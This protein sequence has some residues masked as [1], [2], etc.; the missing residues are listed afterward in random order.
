MIRFVSPITQKPLVAKDYKTLTC[1]ESGE[2]FYKIDGIWRMLD[3]ARA[4][5]FSQFIEEYELIRQAEGRKESDAGY[6][7]LPFTPAEHP[8][9]TMWAERAASFQFLKDSVLPRGTAS[10]LTVLDL[11]A[12]NGW[13]SNQL[14][15]MD[16]TVAAVDLTVN[17]FDGLGVHPHYSADFVPIQ[18]EFDQLP[19]GSEQFDVVI[20]NAS[21]HYSANYLPT[22]QEA[23]RVCKRNGRIIIMD[24]PIYQK[25]ESGTDMVAEREASFKQKFGTRS[26]SLVSENFLT[27]H[28]LADLTQQ[29]GL[30]ADVLSRHPQWRLASR[31][32]KRQLRGERPAAE[33]PL[34]ILNQTGGTYA[35]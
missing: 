12:G 13:L 18:A 17:E 30:D 4:E 23:M 35:S 31:R 9:A 5:R 14:A 22:L 1:P 27:P 8:L 26:N 20:F 33:F 6:S 25:S 34:I 21:F 7:Q 15:L 16:H 19:L 32:L 11:G 3:P 2:L 24:T 10:N 29:L 28:R